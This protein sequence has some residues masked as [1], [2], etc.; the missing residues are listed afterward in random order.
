VS[1]E[2]RSLVGA[3]VEVISSSLSTEKAMRLK[4]LLPHDLSATATVT[5][6]VTVTVTE[7]VSVTGTADG[8]RC[9]DTM[10]LC[11]DTM[12]SSKRAWNNRELFDS[13]G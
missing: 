8:S 10:M 7:T 9:F 3:A 12:R 2:A 13:L 6:T 11:D 1:D 4:N 5:V